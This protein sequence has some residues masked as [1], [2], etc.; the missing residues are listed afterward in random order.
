[1]M[2]KSDHNV[3]LKCFSTGNGV[4]LSENVNEKA[5]EKYLSGDKQREA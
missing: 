3:I 5:K 1:M 2:Q 4:S